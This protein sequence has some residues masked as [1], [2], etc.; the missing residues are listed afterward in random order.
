MKAKWLGA[1]IVFAAVGG[2]TTNNNTVLT[3][4]DMA[5]ASP[6]PAC[7]PNAKECV[8][9]TLARVCP[10]DGSGWLAVQCQN[11]ET[12]K[13]GDCGLDVTTVPCLPSDSFCTSDTTALI[14]N[15]NGMGFSM[16][17]CPTNTQC[18]NGGD[19]LGSSCIIG[20]SI[21]D[22]LLVRNCS[23]D[24][25]TYTMPSHCPTG[26]ACSDMAGGLCA[27]AACTPGNCNFECGNKA[28]D[29]NSTDSGFFSTCQ[30]TGLGWRWISLA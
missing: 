22:G 24:G 3:T 30:D 17:T 21:C 6:A 14:C 11:G 18:V 19:C 15:G 23:A 27:A 2:C 9:S 29:P 25:S 5:G 7:T 20:S 26:Q 1:A 4:P 13:G 16:K 10:A 28:T 12:C 8:S